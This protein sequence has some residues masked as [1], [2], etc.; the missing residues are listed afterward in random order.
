MI[1][2]VTPDHSPGYMNFWHLL[3]WILESWKQ[4]YSTT[5]LGIKT[6]LFL[7]QFRPFIL[8]DCVE[9]R[10]LTSRD[11]DI[12]LEWYYCHSR[13]KINLRWELIQL[14]PAVAAFIWVCH[15]LQ[16]KSLKHN[17]L[18]LSIYN[19][20]FHWTMIHSEDRI[21]VLQHEWFDDANHSWYMS[22]K[23][24]LMWTTSSP[25][26]F[27]IT[28]SHLIHLL[29]NHNQW[30]GFLSIVSHFLITMIYSMATSVLHDHPI[31]ILQKYL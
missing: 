25:Q 3:T 5:R 11:L 27:T 29:L 21:V 9:Y 20:F 26:F 19:N 17:A 10:C 15:F 28:M 12:H 18:D 2:M 24:L 23:F 16:M 31:W 7:M 22:G 14:Y 30:H 1:R 13:C 4:N 6:N 8:K